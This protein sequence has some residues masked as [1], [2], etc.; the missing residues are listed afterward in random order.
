MPPG[1]TFRNARRAFRTGSGHSN[2]VASSV[3]SGRIV[4][5]LSD[6]DMTGAS[7][8]AFPLFY[9]SRRDTATDDHQ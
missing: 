2:P 1:G 6:C 5:L 7:T 8:I 4:V 9:R 3:L